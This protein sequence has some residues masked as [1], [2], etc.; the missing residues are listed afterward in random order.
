MWLIV[1]AK[2]MTANDENGG[3]KVVLKEKTRDANVVF[4]QIFVP[5][6]KRFSS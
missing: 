3:N 2:G 5:V 4:L 6:D 1:V